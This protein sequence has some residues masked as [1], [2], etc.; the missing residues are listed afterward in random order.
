M[1]TITFQTIDLIKES[2]VTDLDAAINM[3]GMEVEKSTY[4]G[5]ISVDITP[6]R[7]DLLDIV[8][9]GRALGNITEK[10][11]RDGGRYIAKNKP[12]TEVRIT[13]AVKDIR[14]F[15]AAIV[16]KGID[17]RGNRLKYLINFT[18][19]ISDTYGR[20]RRKIAIGIHDFDKIGGPLVYDAPDRGKIVPLGSSTEMS[21]GDVIAT[22]AKGQEYIS[23]I[24]REG[25]KPQK[26][27]AISDG[28]KTIALVPIINS[29]DTAVTEKTRNIL[30]DITGTS[31]KAIGEIANLL[32]CSFMDSGAEIHPVTISDGGKTKVTPDLKYREIKVK[33][34]AVDKMV[35]SRIGERVVEYANMTGYTASRQGKTAILNVPPY[36][37]DVLNEQEIFQLNCSL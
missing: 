6:N 3:L 17:L 23:T 33:I 20:R 29:A 13:G 10:K 14:P 11:M 35:G 2:G 36:R 27:P 30:V 8:G 12:I 26:Y 37:T 18:N 22:Q 9:L 28:K 21:F 32:A 16:A 19:K 31:E 5:E 25:A 4:E 24:A 7:P 34:P 1:A 15:I